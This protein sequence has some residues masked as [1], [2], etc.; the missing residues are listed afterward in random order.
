MSQRLTPDPRHGSRSSLRR[1][2]VGAIAVLCALAAS[3]PAGAAADST[4]VET[5]PAGDA[6]NVCCNTPPRYWRACTVLR[7]SP[8]VL[9]VQFDRDTI[10]LRLSSI[11]LRNAVEGLRGAGRTRAL[12]AFAEGDR[13]GELTA[14][15]VRT[16]PGR[17]LL[18]MLVVALPLLG[19]AA[20]L[21]RGWPSELTRG[22]DGPHSASTWQVVVWF[23]AV[24]ILFGATVLLRTWAGGIAYAAGIMVPAKLLAL[25]GISA[26]TFA[27]ARA[28]R[29]VKETREAKKRA[30]EDPGPPRKSA[31]FPRDLVQEGDAPPDLGNI[32]LV[33][34]TLIVLSIYVVRVFAWLAQVELSCTIS[35]PDVDTT[36]LGATGV[37]YGVYLA[38][39]VA[40][41]L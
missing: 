29:H 13:Q 10:M 12:V 31:S 18:A 2:R 11:E 15:G 14:I 19:L 6:I 23:T 40:T 1:L 26:S 20:L 24:V 16:T 22:I 34:V 21:A 30:P 7:Y 41:L 4:D 37:G 28:V 27:G 36:L 5:F 8:D 33:I 39:K 9:F 25:M 35:L 17:R 32:Q 3:A 38:K